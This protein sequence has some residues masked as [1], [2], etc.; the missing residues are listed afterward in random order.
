MPKPS[1]RASFL[2]PC[3]PIGGSREVPAATCNQAKQMATKLDLTAPNLKAF[4]P[5]EGVEVIWDARLPGFGLRTRGR[6]VTSSWSWIVK[7]NHIADR[8]SVKTTLGRYAALTPAQARAMATDHLN[9]AKV[10]GAD[11]RDKLRDE[12]QRRSAVKQAAEAAEEA[13][14]LAQEAEAARPDF[15][16]LWDRYWEVEGCMKK[17]AKGYLHLWNYHLR[18]H[19]ACIKVG[20]LTPEMVEDFKIAKVKTPG[21]ANRAIAILSILLSKAV[22]WGWRRGCSPEHP[23]KGGAVSRYAERQ[24][25]FYFSEEQLGR[26]LQAADD[27][28][29]GARGNY[30]RGDGVG[31]VIRMLALTGARAGE[32]LKA[33]WGQFEPLD[34]GRLLWTVESTNTKQGRAIARVLDP[35]MS[36]RLLVWKPASLALTA[37][38]GAAKPRWVFPQ[39]ANPDQPVLRIENAWRKIKRAAEIDRGRIHD[40]RH[41][42]A[43]LMLRRCKSLS[44]VQQQLGHATPLTTNRYAHVMPMGAVENG[45]LLGEIAASADLA[46]RSARVS[47]M[48]N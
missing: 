45:D 48:A 7:Y 31:L 17:S 8:T 42:V 11:F 12:R 6:T 14:R 1:Q 26:I 18:A 32:V 39:A 44:S 20:D 19:F 41:T 25:D 22:A 5:P 46:A 33:H 27:Y 37:N 3:S 15:Q 23:I 38:C 2:G 4:V 10:V 35:A 30:V 43:T 28:A 29:G 40:L 9:A 36:K 13:V 21:S 47:R 24:I 34:G 16:R